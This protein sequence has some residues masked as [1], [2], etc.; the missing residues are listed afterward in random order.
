MEIGAWT[1]MNDVD[2]ADD[3]ILYWAIFEYVTGEQYVKRLTNYRLT[4]SEAWAAVWSHNDLYGF[5]S[6]D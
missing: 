4:N 5:G 2:E 1:A 3:G 6:D